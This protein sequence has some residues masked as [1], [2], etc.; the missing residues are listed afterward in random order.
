MPREI[1]KVAYKFE[2]DFKKSFEPIVYLNLILRRLNSNHQNRFI[3]DVFNH[4]D[5]FSIDFY[6]L[7][8]VKGI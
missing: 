8:W 7:F 6:I 5:E 2:G 4:Q 1:I 3:Q